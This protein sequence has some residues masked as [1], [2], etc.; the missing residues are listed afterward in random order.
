MYRRGRYNRGQKAA[1][2]RKRVVP[3]FME[4]DNGVSTFEIAD[5]LSILLT[6]PAG[7]NT[8]SRAVNLWNAF[9]L[10]Q[11]YEN[12]LGMFDSVHLGRVS[13]TLT[14]HG[15]II[16]SS[17]SSS[18]TIVTAFDRNGIEPLA[19]S[20][21][22]YTVISTYQS[23]RIRQ[24]AVGSTIQEDIY[25]EP[26]SAAETMFWVPLG[27]LR[28]PTGADDVPDNP[29]NVFSSPMVPYK[30]T[31]LVGAI[32]PLVVAAQQTLQFSCQI[33]FDLSFRGLRKPVVPIAPPAP[34]PEPDPEETEPEEDPV[35]A[36]DPTVTVISSAY[37]DRTQRVLMTEFNYGSLSDFD[38]DPRK[39]LLIID[40]DSNSNYYTVFFFA[41]TADLSAAVG[42][43]GP[44]YY[45]EAPLAEG[46][47]SVGVEFED[48]EQRAVMS[49]KEDGLDG[50][51][52]TY[53][54]YKRFFKFDLPPQ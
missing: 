38:L 1:M 15:Q 42:I 21:P 28:P 33:R 8:G 50:D 52:T 41:N 6:I 39:Y 13:I 25:I 32:V 35:P 47:N 37:L 43:I 34:D 20:P 44:Y 26:H 7:G 48:A 22:P 46:Q 17:S 11:Y 27:L 19:G 53:T 9:R 3:R 2:Y 4:G 54:L 51:P 31:L 49:F 12:Y 45:Y 10:S 29:C 14:G 30:P 18:P 16:L 36:P 24:W 40:T 23:A 5:S